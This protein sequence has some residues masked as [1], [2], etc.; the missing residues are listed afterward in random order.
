MQLPARAVSKEETR[1]FFDQAI[2]D[3]YGY[4]LYRTREKSIAEDLTSETMVA[5]VRSLGICPTELPSVAWLI[6]IARHKLLDH[7]RRE[8]RERQHLKLLAIDGSRAALD[9]ER[10]VSRAED[11]L[12]GLNPTQRSRTYFDRARHALAGVEH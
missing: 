12:A 9:I 4:L 1:S 10:E 7:W 8:A 11:A 6:G 3:V 2:P 5:A